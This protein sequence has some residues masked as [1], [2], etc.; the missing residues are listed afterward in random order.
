MLV[1][2]L[3]AEG[4]LVDCDLVYLPVEFRVG[5]GYGYGFVNFTTHQAA[6]AALKVLDGFTDSGKA[7]LTEGALE[8]HWSVKQGLLTHIELYRSSPVMH[9]S[10]DDEAKPALLKSG[11]RM[12]FPEPT[13]R[14][15]APRQRRRIL[16]QPDEEAQ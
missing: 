6:C 12:P 14:L 7:S 5:T 8:A 2:L 1:E 3:A 11:A 13:S 10:V 16:T 9:R 4:L 15:R